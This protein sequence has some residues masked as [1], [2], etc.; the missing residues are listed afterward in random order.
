MIAARRSARGVRPVMAAAI[1][2]MDLPDALLIQIAQG[3][4]SRDR[5]ESGEPLFASF[6]HIYSCPVTTR[7]TDK[8]DG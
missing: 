7:A 2:L 8:A 6:D 5:C 4:S 1:E 3:L